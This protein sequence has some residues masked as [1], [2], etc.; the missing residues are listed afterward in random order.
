MAETIIKK[1]KEQDQKDPKAKMTKLHSFLDLIKK[2]DQ[3]L[4]TAEKSKKIV[5]LKQ[6]KTALTKK[7]TNT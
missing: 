1:L 6:L 3:L 5:T 4:A 7:K 2:T